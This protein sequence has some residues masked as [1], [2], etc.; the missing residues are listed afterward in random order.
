MAGLHFCARGASFVVND[1]VKLGFK[2][3]FIVG[4][5]FGRMSLFYYIHS[6]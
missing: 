3:W 6:Q 1:F 5:L 4:A 2:L